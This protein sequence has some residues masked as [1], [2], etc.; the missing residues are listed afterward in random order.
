VGKS[1]QDEQKLTVLTVKVSLY[2]KAIKEFQ[3]L[4]GQ[5]HIGKGEN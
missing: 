5:V 3:L 4:G 1:F 2:G